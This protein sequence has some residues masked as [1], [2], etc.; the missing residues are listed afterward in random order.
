MLSRAYITY[1][2]E[3]EPLIWKVKF[4][5]LFKPDLTGSSAVT[6]IRQ[7]LDSSTGQPL[8]PLPG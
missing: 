8:T 6:I 5:G 2:F 4:S 1:P 7:I 3:A